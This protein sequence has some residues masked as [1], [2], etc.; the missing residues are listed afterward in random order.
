MLEHIVGA[1][2]R[3]TP[4]SNLTEVIHDVKSRWRMKLALRGAVR[5]VAVAVAV[6]FIAAYALE[7]ARFSPSSIIVARVLLSAA[8]LG[9]VYYFFIRPLRRRVTDEQVALYLEEHEPSLQATLISAVEASGQGGG[10]ESAS[11]ALVTI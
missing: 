3:S 5:S 9:S 8:V 10:G 4:P 7:W 2:R 6:F 11:A 1:Q